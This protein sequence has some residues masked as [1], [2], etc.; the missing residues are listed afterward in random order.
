VI[1]CPLALGGVASAK[2]VSPLKKGL[3]FYAGQTLTFIIPTTAGS[4]NDIEARILATAMGQYLH[5]TIN[6]VD[7]SAGSNITGQDVMAGSTPNGL[8]FGGLN[9]GGDILD[10]IT[11]TP[12]L[13][14][15]P[16]RLAFLG[17]MAPPDHTLAVS[18]TSP[19]KTFAEML[20]APASDPVTLLE[21]TGAT[22]LEQY[23]LL[24]AFNINARSITGYSGSSA[25]VTGLIRGDGMGEIN[26][27][28]TLGTLFISH[29]VLP[30]MVM[31]RLSAGVNYSAITAKTPT[32][33]QL[34]A[35]Y[36][37]KTKLA[38]EA[39]TTLVDYQANSGYIYAAPSATPAPEVAAL[40]QAMKYAW[41]QPSTKT[42]LDVLG[43]G[44]DTASGAGAKAS[45]LAAVKAVNK[46]A[47]PLGLAA[48]AG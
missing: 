4:N 13:S 37:P 19:Y 26:A 42:Q 14:F 15:D 46:Y 16:S 35:K 5:A 29:Q 32:I 48:A 6:V 20:K 36:P 38:K 24:K 3:E 34:A 28:G 33:A 47:G 7:N 18:P 23:L 45:Y 12:G 9:T 10:A 22:T 30:V 8:T 39:L 43:E 11:S 21:D 17:E 40:R 31:A 41:A 2:T 1:F 25:L 27:T 44:I